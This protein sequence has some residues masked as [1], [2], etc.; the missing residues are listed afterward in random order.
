M[1]KRILIALLTCATILSGCGATTE[2]PQE[3]ESI[4]EEEDD[5]EKEEESEVEES[6]EAAEVD[7]SAAVPEFCLSFYEPSF[8]YVLCRMS[9]ISVSLATSSCGLR[10]L[11]REGY[12]S[13]Q[14]TSGGVRAVRIL[15]VNDVSVTLLIMIS[16]PNW[17]NTWEVRERSNS[18]VTVLASPWYI[19]KAERM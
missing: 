14:L 5:E 17:S 3:V 8:W 7:L 11:I 2:E 18:A 6:T 4:T 19:R 16:L 12:C 13:S 1:K 15:A 10:T 9:A